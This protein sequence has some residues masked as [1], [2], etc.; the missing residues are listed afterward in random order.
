LILPSAILQKTQFGSNIGITVKTLS[1]INRK[2][3]YFMLN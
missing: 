3:L 2:L 1:L